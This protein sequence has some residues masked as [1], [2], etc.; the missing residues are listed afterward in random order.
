MVGNGHPRRKMNSF[1]KPGGLYGQT[2]EPLSG[3]LA[4]VFGIRPAAFRSLSQTAAMLLVCF[5]K[6][7]AVCQNQKSSNHSLIK[8]ECGD[9]VCHFF[10]LV[11]DSRS[12]SS[13]RSSTPEAENARE[14]HGADDAANAAR[15]C[16]PVRPV[17]SPRSRRRSRRLRRL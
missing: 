4:Y 14:M 17:P 2:K 11:P 10:W 15:P 1:S 12:S 8:P 13:L 9:V 3:H 16:A 5:A 6:P 7:G